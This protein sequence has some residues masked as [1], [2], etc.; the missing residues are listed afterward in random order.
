MGSPPAG[1]DLG[2]VGGRFWALPNDDDDL[3]NAPAASP[4]PSDIVCESILVGYSEEQIAESI[5]GL[6]PESDP[7]W[8]GLTANAEDR[9]EVLRRVVHRRTTANAIRPWKGPLPKGLMMG[10]LLQREPACGRTDL[11]SLL[12]RDVGLRVLEEEVRESI[13]AVAEVDSM[14]TEVMQISEM[15]I[16]LDQVPA[17]LIGLP[18]EVPG[19]DTTNGI[20]PSSHP[21]AILSKEFVEISDKEAGAEYAIMGGITMGRYGRK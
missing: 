12:V 5:D 3:Q 6:V 21:K 4:T 1:R 10:Y 17:G 13:I 20:A 14:D 11:R 7:A 9:V 2:L 15:T 16:L 8:E 18:E 19:E